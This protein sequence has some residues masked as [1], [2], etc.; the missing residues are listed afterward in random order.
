MLVLS[1]SNAPE[2][3]RNAL[4]IKC[5]QGRHAYMPAMNGNSCCCCQHQPDKIEPRPCNWGL[6][7]QHEAFNPSCSAIHNLGCLIFM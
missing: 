7:L 3:S 5:S 1:I 6:P 4:V 2:M